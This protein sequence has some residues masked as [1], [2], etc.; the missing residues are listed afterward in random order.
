MPF[1]MPALEAPFISRNTSHST[2]GGNDRR[3]TVDGTH[4]MPHFHKLKLV[5]RIPEARGGLMTGLLHIRDQAPP[6]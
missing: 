5:P 2:Y 1:V 3:D 6:L 4:L